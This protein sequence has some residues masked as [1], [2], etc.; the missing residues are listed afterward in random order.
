MYFFLVVIQPMI[1]DLQAAYALNLNIL[2]ADYG[3]L[4]GIILD[5]SKAT[6]ILQATAVTLRYH[7]EFGKLKLWWP[8]VGPINLWRPNTTLEDGRILL[9]PLLL[10]FLAKEFALAAFLPVS[11][12][13]LFAAPIWNDVCV[14]G[15]LRE[16]MARSDD[17]FP[18]VFKMNDLYISTEMHRFCASVFKFLHVFLILHRIKRR[19]CPWRLM[20]VVSSGKTTFC[21][22]YPTG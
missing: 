6:E 1:D 3:K 2:C 19:Q 12:I 11:G 10:P 5:I 18:D 13:K 7:L 15:F 22:T 9:Q 20:S 21:L 8:I 4:V 14:T 17:L 16:Q